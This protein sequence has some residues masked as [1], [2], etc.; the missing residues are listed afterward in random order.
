M[1]ACLLS[2]VGDVSPI[3]SMS[4]KADAPSG[5]TDATSLSSKGRILM[6]NASRLTVAK[7][8]HPARDTSYK[9][10]LKV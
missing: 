3:A 10:R 8:F 6:E 9:M 4:G 1:Q 7:V 2:L 5:I